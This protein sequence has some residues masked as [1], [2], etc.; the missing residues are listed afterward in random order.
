MTW[1]IP[2]IPHWK[3]PEFIRAC[4]AVCFL[5]RNFPIKIHTPT[6]PREILACGRCL[7]LSREI[8]EKQAYRDLLV[9]RKNFVLI[10]NPQDIKSLTNILLWTIQHRSL[11]KKIGSEGYKISRSIEDFDN[12]INSRNEMFLKFQKLT[13]RKI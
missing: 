6:V 3:V 1:L 5:E 10:E 13:R 11:V 12:F 8:M 4:D 7:L 9:D 2:V